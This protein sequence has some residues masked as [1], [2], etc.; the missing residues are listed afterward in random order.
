M[1]NPFSRLYKEYLNRKVLVKNRLV[2]ISCISTKVHFG[3][4]TLYGIRFGK[5]LGSIITLMA[6]MQLKEIRAIALCCLMIH[7]KTIA[8]RLVSILLLQ[9]F[10]L[11]SKP[12]YSSLGMSEG[13]SK[14]K[15]RINSAV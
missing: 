12:R 8:L 11:F 10:S 14:D 7:S 1:I 2:F 6:Y 9:E 15:E 5:N 3:N 4:I 13:H